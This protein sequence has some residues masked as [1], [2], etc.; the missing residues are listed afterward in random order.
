[1]PLLVVPFEAL[2]VVSLQP[3]ST[4]PSANVAGTQGETSILLSDDDAI[5]HVDDHPQKTNSFMKFLFGHCD[6]EPA[7][8][9]FDKNCFRVTHNSGHTTR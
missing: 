9:V 3:Y 6:A 7:H 2:V 1:M 4:G 5:V 8:F